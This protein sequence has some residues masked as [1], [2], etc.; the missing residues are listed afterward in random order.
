MPD[1]NNYNLSH[2]EKL[3]A[4]VIFIMREAM[5]EFSNSVMHIDTGFKF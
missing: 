2:I 1:K 3:E 4:E 5:V